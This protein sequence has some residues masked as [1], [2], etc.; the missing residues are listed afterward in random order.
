MKT[1]LAVLLLLIPFYCFSQIENK[2]NNYKTISGF[3]THNNKALSN[4]NIFVKNT[5]SY[6]VSDSKGFYSVKAKVGD[7]LSFDYVGL[8]KVTILIEDVTS[9]LNIEM[10]TDKNILSFKYKK[11]LKLGESNIGD[12]IS[13]F[14]IKAIKGENLDKNASSLANAIV[15]KT[16]EL[17]LR[18]NEYGQE[19]VYIRG[20]ELQG[21]VVWDIDGYKYDIPLPIF[22]SE[23]KN[24]IIVS[25]GT[26]KVN[27]TIDY[28][29]VNDIVFEN[30]Y[31]IE[32]DFYNNDAITYKKLK[33]ESPSYLNKFNKIKKTEKALNLYLETYNAD[34]K[35]INYHFNVI[36]LFEKENYSKTS[37]LKVLSDFEK[38]SENNPEDLKA[39]AYKYQ[40]IN[41][42]EKAIAIYKKLIKLRPNYLQSY[43]DLGNAFLEEKKY[44]EAWKAYKYYL[45]KNFKIE[46]NDIGEIISSEIISTYNLDINNDQIHKKVKIVNPNKNIESDIRIVFEWNTS[47]AEFI[48]EFVNPIDFT[49]KIE[50][51]QNMNNDLITDQKKKG[52]TS[53]E[54]FIK[55]VESGNWL[56]NL[57]YL[58][59]KQFKPTFFKTTT[60]YN[61][62]RKNQRKEISIFEFT[63]KNIKTQLLKFNQNSI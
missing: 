17:F 40:E 21:P 60:Y 16:P 43:R 61:W 18:V 9:T 29:K 34:K 56:V 5:M 12:Y 14:T 45:N 4:A 24:V 33:K 8:K 41:E 44:D 15:E 23:V 55:D 37:I 54:I 19:I 3:I 22:I 20:K 11:V 28:K 47:E 52:Y 59:N 32:N 26:I 10:K 31:F 49:Y 7:L 42:G 58:G 46:K 1:K 36:N 62:G 48:L 63:Q 30:Y 13:D 2:D 50:N 53:K 38:F 27:T 25:N 57:I 39:I 51:S 6:A 35:N